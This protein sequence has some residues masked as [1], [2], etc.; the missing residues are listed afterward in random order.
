[1]E[2]LQRLHEVNT[3]QYN[4]LPTGP[5]PDYV[6]A[7]KSYKTN[8]T[9]VTLDMGSLLD[10]NIYLVLR[11]LDT[12][13]P[14]S[15]RLRALKLVRTDQSIESLAEAFKDGQRPNLVSANIVFSWRT[16]DPLAAERGVSSEN[17]DETEEEMMQ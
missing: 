13:F 10:Q 6:P 1:L 2:T 16:V 4:F 7:M 15:I 8:A 9:T 11:D 17:L 3:L 14:G 12:V 5:D